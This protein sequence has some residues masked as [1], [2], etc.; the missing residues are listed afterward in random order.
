MNWR[1][2][3]SSSLSIYFV[4]MAVPGLRVGLPCP[5]ERFR[6]MNTPVNRIPSPSNGLHHKMLHRPESIFGKRSR[7]QPV[8]VG[9]HQQLA[10]CPSH[11]R[12]GPCIQTCSG[13]NSSFS[14]AS[15]TDNSAAID[16]G[17]R[18]C[19]INKILFIIINTLNSRKTK[20][21]QMSANLQNISKKQET[22]H[23]VYDINELYLI[24]I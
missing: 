20:T 21:W 14:K 5:P 17:C 16:L 12:S 1:R 7:T 2:S 22:I 9:D 24:F 8:L 19:L 18:P 6:S 10:D 13:R 23:K 4:N 11:G 3:Y 15:I